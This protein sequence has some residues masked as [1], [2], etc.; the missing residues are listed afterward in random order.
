L[1]HL[2]TL[3]DKEEKI[4]AAQEAH[5]DT[6][7]VSTPSDSRIQA[8]LKEYE[9]SRINADHLEDSIWNTAAVLVTGSIAGLA[10]LGGTIPENPRPY[11]YLLRAAIG[12]LSIILVYWWKKMTS[13]WYFIQDMLFFRIVEIEEE[14]DLYSESYIIYLDKASRGEKYPERPRVKAMISSMQAQYKPLNVPRTVNRIGWVLII[15]WFI[16]LTA[17]GAA[18]LGW[19]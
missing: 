19:L 5:K 12:L 3:G 14:L 8:L 7:T 15:V 17:Q 2:A 9:L 6:S 4:M 10:L 16:F 13:V 11:D 1:K 18:M